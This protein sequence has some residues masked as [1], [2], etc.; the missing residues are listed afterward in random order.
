MRCVPTGTLRLHAL[1]AARGPDAVYGWL[2]SPDGAARGSVRGLRPGRYRL[3]WYDPWTGEPVAEPS[4][5]PVVVGS[6]GTAI[7]DAGRVLARLA[8]SAP[9]FPRSSRLARGRDAAFKLLASR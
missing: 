2:F 1:H 5:Q 9:P 7:L 8:A 3:V 6:S 4:A